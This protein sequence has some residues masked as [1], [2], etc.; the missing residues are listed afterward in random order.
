MRLFLC[1]EKGCDDL[2]NK[3]FMKKSAGEKRRRLY[4][5]LE[6]IAGGSLDDVMIGLIIPKVAI[7]RQY[8][9]SA[10]SDNLA[11]QKAIAR[12]QTGNSLLSVVYSR[13][14]NGT[15]AVVITPRKQDN[16]TKNTRAIYIYSPKLYYRK[17]VKKWAKASKNG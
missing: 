16:G 7:H 10:F 3:V 9:I 17:G 8:T 2:K 13:A 4:A 14:G 12:A 11:F 6:H 15:V 1:L 5:V